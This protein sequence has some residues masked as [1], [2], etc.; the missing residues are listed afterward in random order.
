MPKRLQA[1]IQV[2]AQSPAADSHL[3]SSLPFGQAR[4]STQLDSLALPDW[5]GR[6]GLGQG[7][8]VTVA[9]PLSQFVPGQLAT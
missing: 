4:M 7:L 5:K 8:P 9:E 1:S 6:K 2:A 3:L